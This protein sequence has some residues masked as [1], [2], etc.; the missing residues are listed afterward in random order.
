MPIPSSSVEFASSLR[1]M[2]H[3]ATA[4]KP[5]SMSRSNRGSR[6]IKQSSFHTGK[7]SSSR[8]NPYVLITS[9]M[10]SS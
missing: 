8:G 6:D 5:V 1:G 4:T 7:L 3:G 2:S 9:F 10:Q